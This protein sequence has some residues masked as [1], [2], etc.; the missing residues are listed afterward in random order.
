L[1]LQAVEICTIDRAML[2]LDNSYTISRNYEILNSHSVFVVNE[3]HLS[4]LTLLVISKK[5]LSRVVSH[6]HALN[7]SILT[8]RKLKLNFKS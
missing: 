8:H 2:L 3:V 1:N 4:L 6:T 5:E 7:Q